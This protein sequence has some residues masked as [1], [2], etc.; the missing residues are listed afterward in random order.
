MTLR[1][2]RNLCAAL[3]NVSDEWSLRILFEELGELYKGFADEATVE[4][5]ELPTSVML[6]SAAPG[7]IGLEVDSVG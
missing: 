7:N 1:R 2:A 6:P 3:R 4:L 5:P